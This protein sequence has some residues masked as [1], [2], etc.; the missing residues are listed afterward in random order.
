M[1]EC[2]IGEAS[3]RLGLSPDTLR[4]YER[5]GLLPPVARNLSGLR[6]YD[7]KDFA[8]L[9]FIQR[10]QKM[11]FTLAEI[12]QLLKMRETKQARTEVRDLAHHKLLQIEN[13][14]KEL[15]V[16]RKELRELVELCQGAKAGCPIIERFD[17][18]D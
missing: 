16:L 12:S 1:A 11:N 4:Y 13:R 18:E 5:I 10:A 9:R 6:V 2:H 3:K 7:G 14:L 8:R 15:R 17:H